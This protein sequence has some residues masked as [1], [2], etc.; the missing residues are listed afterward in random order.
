MAVCGVPCIV[1]WFRRHDRRTVALL[2]LGG[3]AAFVFSHGMGLLIGP[4]PG[5]ILTAALTCTGYWR[6]SDSP[7]RG[8]RL[9][10]L[11]V[12]S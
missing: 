11:P 4:W 8:G 5:V 6:L 1:I 2:T 3:L 12:G 9:G 10:R 7:K